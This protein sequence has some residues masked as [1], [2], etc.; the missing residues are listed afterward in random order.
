[1]LSVTEAEKII[2][3]L[4]QPFDLDG[5]SE[6]IDLSQGLQRILATDIHSDWDIPLWHNAAMDGYALRYADLANLDLNLEACQLAIAP[7]EIA[8]GNDAQP[9][10]GNQ[11]CMR[12]FT[13]GMLPLGADT[14]VMQEDTEVVIT[15]AGRFLKL[16]AKPTKGEY[17][18]HQGEFIKAGDRLLQAGTRLGAPEIGAIAAI[19]R[20]QVQTF[21]QP[22]VAIISTG[23]ELVSLASFANSSQGSLR[24]GKIIDSNLYALTALVT[25][26][27]AIA[28][29]LGVVKDDRETIKQLILRAIAEADLII[30]SGGVSVGDYDYV[31]QILESIG[32]NIQGRSV[33]IKPGKPLTIATLPKS[34]QQSIAYLGVPG[35]PASAIMSFWRFIRGAIA[36]LSGANPIEWVPQFM[37]AQTTQDLH[38][39]GRRET[40]L[41]GKLTYVKGKP[42]FT[43]IQN[44]SS[45]NLVSMVSTNAIAVMRVHQT[46]VP[47]GDEVIVMLV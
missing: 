16:K 44:Y 25:Q 5:N 14:V 12:I 33:A 20:A 11:E 27:G 9:P 4:V 40:Y 1:M 23:D 8:A 36:K 37:Q 24:A 19:G 7:T 32:A 39:Q 30:S 2:L 34:A 15:E 22:K 45:G 13:G 43:P 6:L 35:N 47:Q 38:S 17:V 10:L 29:P 28:L 18:R 41:W 3:N 21:R 26:A 46:Y 42:I 31:E